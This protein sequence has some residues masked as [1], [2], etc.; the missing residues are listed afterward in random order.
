MSYIFLERMMKLKNLIALADR[1]AEVSTE[2]YFEDTNNQLTQDKISVPI[3]HYNGWCLGQ[4]IF[5][6]VGDSTTFALTGMNEPAVIIAQ[7]MSLQG[8]L[9]H[10]KTKMRKVKLYKSLI[11]FLAKSS[12]LWR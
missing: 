8:V 6:R 2:L 3:Y 11:H 7:K 12:S 4:L 9:S 10:K 5:S 1:K